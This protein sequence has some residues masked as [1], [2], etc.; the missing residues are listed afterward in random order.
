MRLERI[1]VEH[2]G[3]I[4]RAAVD[5]G[6]GLNVLYGPNDIGKSTLAHAI[7]AALL[8]QHSS[9][10]ASRYFEWDSDEKP[11]VKLT[12]HLPNGRL[13]R[14]E[15]RFGSPGGSSVLRESSDGKNWSPYKKGREVDEE[16]RTMLGWGI[17]RPGGR[18]APKGLPASFLST[19]LLGEQMDV[20]GVLE[21]TLDADTN[22]TGREKLT[23]ALAAFAQDPLFKSVLEAA[24]AKVDQAFTP[25]GKRKRG[26]SSPFK[27]A[28]EEVT[29]ITQV[30][31]ALKR[32]VDESESA[33]REL[34]ERRAD[35]R[36]AQEAVEAAT[37]RHEA[38]QKL[39][40]QTEARAA[41]EK[42]LAPVRERLAEQQDAVE[43]LSRAR[44]ELG[45]AN[46]A[47]RAAQAAHQDA[48]AAHKDAE[49]EHRAAEEAVRRAQ[50]GDAEAERQLQK[51]GLEKKKLEL[52][53]LAKER[54][55][56]LAELRRARTLTT[57]IGNLERSAATLADAQAQY[58]KEIARAETE[59]AQIQ[60][61]MALL[62]IAARLGERD[63][64]AEQVTQLEGVAAEV[65]A[66]REKAAERRAKAAE[67][68]A[69]IRDDLPDPPQLEEL[70][71]LSQQLA[72]AEA[73]LG[74]GLS[75]VVER[76]REVGVEVR[77]DGV[78][79][80]V[81][82]S[83]EV[84]F[85]AD[86]AF[87]IQLGDVARV[88]VEAGERA[89][90]E[91]VGQLRE[92]HRQQ[93]APVLEAAR[94]SS[95]EELAERVT[96]NEAREAAR[97]GELN[98]AWQLEKGAQLRAE[99]LSALDRLRAELA[100]SAR[101]LEGQP[102][103]EARELL[104]EIGASRLDAERRTLSNGL[105]AA[106]KARDAA[107]MAFGQNEGRAAV[108][109][110]QLETKRQSLAELD[111][112]APE[113]GWDAAEVSLERR[114][115]DAESQS[116]RVAQELQTLSA[117]Q[118]Q[119]VEKAEAQLQAAKTKIQEAARRLEDAWSHANHAQQRVHQLEGQ[120]AAQEAAIEKIDLEAT[121]AQVAE[122]EQRLDALPKP[123]RM[124]GAEELVLARDALNRAERA[125]ETALQEVRKAE[126]A[127]QAVGGQVVLEERDAAQEA[128]LLAKQREAEVEVEYDAWRL[129]VDTLREAENTEGTHLG[130]ALSEPVSRRFAELTQARYGVLDLGPSLQTEGL[131]VAGVARELASFSAGTQEQLATLLRLTVAEH[132]ETM[133][134]LDDHLVQT[135][136]ARSEWFR[137]VLREHGARRQVVVLTCRPL[138]YLDGDELAPGQQAHMSRAAALVR[139][140][141]IEHLVETGRS[142]SVTESDGR[143]P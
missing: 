123:D 55:E 129:L 35:H 83:G 79:L 34:D 2:F 19:V 127:L 97:A 30:I 135:D 68:E 69:T 105:D 8:I 104:D 99:Q 28:T 15:K 98:A 20:V 24:Q 51:A 66:D 43:A 64:L 112:A 82:D 95:L 113:E 81:A 92:R 90:R 21:A 124:V 134:I 61:R 103:P 102:L 141:A 5:F 126:G 122:I 110:S 128:L 93:V 108:A 101:E 86:R 50:S 23:A 136:P 120:L 125:Q 130:R 73:R 132:L 117:E 121:R 27:E 3:C 52:D 56:R 59:R 18:G 32:R 70:R 143:A 76:L 114:V 91:E 1:E 14:I 137:R 38:L 45:S 75:V 62:G 139:A 40:H 87:E 53:G 7:R 84:A 9:N 47:H 31:D 107:K 133:L 67:I 60:Q 116:R 115:H 29:R 16:L 6:P 109:R 4:R 118:G 10:A 119:E 100:A 142:G 11:Y 94:A 140:T 54:G 85:E 22:D 65:A 96:E 13:W 46:E 26:K 138:D 63:R 74:G 71:A 17:Q 77:R 80:D 106:Q 111:L 72:V 37:A 49:S 57:E 44:E 33:K 25:K 48:A 89:A 39:V 42:E 78:P 58:E 88:T 36:R 41:V 12:L 131:Q